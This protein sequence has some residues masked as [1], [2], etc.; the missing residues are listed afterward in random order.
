V[1]RRG[2]NREGL[3]AL[4]PVLD[5]RKEE[6]AGAL[7]AMPP[8]RASPF[9]RIGSTHFARLVLMDGFPD[10]HAG[11]LADMPACLFFGAEF[12]IPV[13][14][15]LEALCS[16]M[17]DEADA[18]FR[19]CAEYPGASVPPLVREWMLR[20]RIRPGFSILGNPQASVRQVVDALR[21]REQIIGFAVE[22][23]G[24]APGALKGAWDS[25]DWGSAA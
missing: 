23:R 5:G 10:R 12:D 4:L 22:T 9:A 1:R 13:A 16:L 8:G 17:P 15:Y 24:L 2:F 11:R 21:L 25:K 20:H 19:T 7:E 6:L 3:A 14:G 18:V